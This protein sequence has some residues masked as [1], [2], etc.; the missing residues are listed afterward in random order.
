MK[1]YTYDYLHQVVVKIICFQLVFNSNSNPLVHCRHSFGYCGY[2]EVAGIE[3]LA[4]TREATDWILC[5]LGPPFSLHSQQRSE[6]G[7]VV[8]MVLDLQQLMHKGEWLPAST[9]LLGLS[10]SHSCN[11]MIKTGWVRGPKTTLLSHDVSLT[12]QYPGPQKTLI[13]FLEKGR[14]VGWI[15]ESWVSSHL[16]AF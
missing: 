6:N 14:S 5:V 7:E 10:H 15:A 4:K 9:P 12:F 16:M 11:N 3:A 13:R 1:T 2:W 8:R